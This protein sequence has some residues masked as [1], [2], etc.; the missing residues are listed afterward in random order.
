MSRKLP[1]ALTAGSRG[2]SKRPGPSTGVARASLVAPAPAPRYV[3]RLAGAR[4]SCLCR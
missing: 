3:A 1:A 4:G 2:S